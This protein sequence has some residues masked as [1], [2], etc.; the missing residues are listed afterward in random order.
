MPVSK[1]P[2]SKADAPSA[3]PDR[4]AMESFL[5]A[6][7]GRRG[8]DATAKAQDVMYDAWERTT[9]HLPFP[10]SASPAKH[11]ASRRSAL[12]LMSFWPKKPRSIEEARDLYAKGV[13]AGELRSGH[14]VSKSMPATSGAF[15]KYA[16]IWGQG[17]SCQ[18][19]PAAWRRRRCPRPLLRHAKAKPERQSGD[20]PSG[21]SSRR[22]EAWRG[23]LPLSPALL[24]AASRAEPAWARRQ[25]WHPR[26]VPA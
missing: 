19:A 17:R 7:A 21:R 24:A 12:T 9:S 23:G 20:H 25:L 15:S 2:R 13:E 8:D 16:P 6:I 14:A 11:S 4:R 18:H 3:L 10:D 1:K 26:H 5:A 22:Y